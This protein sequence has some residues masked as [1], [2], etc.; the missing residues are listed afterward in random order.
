MDFGRWRGFELCERKH[1]RDILETKGP[2]LLH[3]T[4]F[5][6]YQHKNE[7]IQPSSIKTHQHYNKHPILTYQR[8]P[9]ASIGTTNPRRLYRERIAVHCKASALGT[10]CRVFS[11]ERG[12]TYISHWAFNPS[13]L[14]V[15][16]F[17][18]SYLLLSFF[19]PPLSLI[20]FTP[21]V[22]LDIGTVPCSAHHI[23]L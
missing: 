20:S 14:T 21:S 10:R 8:T 13:F 12:C 3:L 15:F 17:C 2:L 11:V 4:H 22:V 18:L 5:K 1:V 16:F 7:T 9:S 19:L 6:V 23:G